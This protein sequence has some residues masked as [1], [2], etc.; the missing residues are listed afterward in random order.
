MSCTCACHLLLLLAGHASSPS[1]PFT[2]P[3][4]FNPTLLTPVTLLQCH[5][6]ALLAPYLHAPCSTGTTVQEKVKRP[7]AWMKEALPVARWLE[8]GLPFDHIF[9]GGWRH[10]VV[11]TLMMTG[12]FP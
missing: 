10:Q 7:E 9:L 5:N 11:F 4:A 3:P 2:Q 12:N 1:L 6:N 8:V